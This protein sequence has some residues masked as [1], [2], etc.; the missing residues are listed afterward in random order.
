ML[1]TY[2]TQRRLMTVPMARGVL[3]RDMLEATFRTGED[4]P[5]RVF[6]TRHPERYDHISA[7]DTPL[8]GAA[9][10]EGLESLLAVPLMARGRS[11][12]VLAAFARA[13]EAFSAEDLDLLRT[14]ASQAALAI[15]TA[16]MFSKEHHVA[17][18]LQES[19]LPARL[20]RIP[21]IDASSIYLPAGS[22]ADIGGDYY[23]LFRGPDGTVFVAMGD[24]CGKGVVAATK[25]SMIKYSV[26]AMAAAGLGPGRILKEIND[27]L[28]E[29]GDPENI[30]TLWV[31]RLDIAGATL[32]YANAG[33]PP[34][35]LLDPGTSRMARLATT[36]PLLGA[37]T[38]AEWALHET[39]VVPGG[40]LLLYTDG[41]TEARSDGSFFG[42]GR[43]RRVLRRGGEA[44]MVTQ[45]LLAMVQRFSGGD[46]RDDAAILAV[47]FYPPGSEPMLDDGVGVE[48]AV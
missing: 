12:G 15:D 23:D 27:M 10:R 3:H 42:E 25:T 39:D 18:V 43:V 13:P 34:G 7:V 40:T 48:R 19:I 37:V 46:M 33:H 11:I 45:R 9:S 2:D 21:G 5:G 29:T 47:V 22:D 8:L 1:L 6:E 30:V 20:P 35:L 26:R 36:G 24:V 16:E 17:T 44:A 38:D 14:F 31:G 28:V 4:I 32:Q 41:V